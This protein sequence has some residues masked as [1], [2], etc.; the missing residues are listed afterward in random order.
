VN[1]EPRRPAIA[2]FF[3]TIR[4]KRTLQTPHVLDSGDKYQRT[5]AKMVCPYRASQQALS[6]SDFRA[7]LVGAG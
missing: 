6:D 2:E 4:Q 3:N 1:H 5:W 7:D